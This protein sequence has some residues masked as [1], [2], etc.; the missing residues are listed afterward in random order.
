MTQDTRPSPEKILYEGKA[1]ILLKSEDG[2]RSTIQFFKDDVTAF[3]AQKLAQIE[4]KGVLSNTIS[5]GLFAWLKKRGVDSH[6]L[7]RVSD[8]QMRVQLMKMIPLE[9]V[10]R[11]IAAGSL[12]KRLGAVRGQRL[13]QPLVEFYLK[14]D[15][16]G[17]PLVTQDHILAFGW[18]NTDEVAKLRS[19]ALTINKLLL[20]LFLSAGFDLVDFKL[21]F[22]RS[23]SSGALLLGDELS[24]D[25]FR[26]WDVK[27]G[28]SYDKD[29][30][31]EDL[32]EVGER[33]QVLQ[34]R[35]S[36][37]LENGK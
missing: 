34:E 18:S 28:E 36:S 16:V 2:G 17:D 24:P 8:R 26:L 7:E 1:K 4:N 23:I 14:N 21:E 10:V 13:S 31:R 25:N 32:G 20:E 37:E 12:V 5:S 30:F 22:G 15:S 27:T 33:Y 19:T 11:N 29:R 3:N 9:V 6:F 35:L